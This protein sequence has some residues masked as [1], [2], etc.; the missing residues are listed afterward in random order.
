MKRAFLSRTFYASILFGVVSATWPSGAAFA[1]SVRPGIS[2]PE[3][4]VQ[5]PDRDRPLLAPLDVEA[6]R[7]INLDQA[8]SDFAVSGEG[9]T[10]AI[11]D[12]GLRTT[13]K[14][15]TNRVVVEAQRNFSTAHPGDP[16]DVTDS[17]GHGTHVAGIIASGLPPWGTAQKARIVPLKVFPVSPGDWTPIENALQ[18]VLDN[19]DSYHISAVNMSLGAG[20]YTSPPSFQNDRIPKLL[21]DLASRRVA[22]VVAAGNDFYPEQSKQGTAYPAIQKEAISVGAFF[23]SD[24]LAQCDRCLVYR[25]GAK[26]C[27]TQIGQLAP[28]SQRLAGADYRTDIFAPGA[29]ITSAGSDSDT[30]MSVDM[31]GTSMA[32]PVTT[33]VVLLMQQYYKRLRAD[34]LPPIEDLKRW[35]SRGPSIKDNPDPPNAPCASDNVIHTGEMFAHLDALAALRAMK[36]ELDPAQP[37]FVM[38]VAQGPSSDAVRTRQGL[39]DLARAYR[40]PKAAGAAKSLE[41]SRKYLQRVGQET[42]QR[43]ERMLKL[44]REKL[45]ETRL[46]MEADR[47]P[48]G[49]QR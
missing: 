36:S 46:L 41:A 38:P 20:N 13:H 7:V 45:D 23:D 21:S 27:R 17:D 1:Q 42:F 32:T 10:V 39:A 47:T 28:F 12:T 43:K 30:N 19:A 4:P 16:S 29:T 44:G 35:L 49:G 15:F 8:R 5:L 26:A 48:G 33:G 25:S 11:L 3:P 37:Q 40:E 6:D 18:W 2:P 34:E 9:M 14:A 22:V 24:A 31:D